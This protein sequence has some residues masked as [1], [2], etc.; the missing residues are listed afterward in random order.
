[1]TGGALRE[2]QSLHLYGWDSQSGKHPPN[3]ALLNMP[4]YAEVRQELYMLIVS[5]ICGYFSLP[6]IR[7]PAWVSNLMLARATPKPEHGHRLYENNI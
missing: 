3:G 7:N 4:T 5:Y 6:S 2:L 1:M